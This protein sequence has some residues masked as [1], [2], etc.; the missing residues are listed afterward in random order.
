VK[1]TTC[2]L[3]PGCQP[4][5]FQNDSLWQIQ[6]TTHSISP[7]I[8]F[9]IPAHSFNQFGSILLTNSTTHSIQF[10]WRIPI[11]STIRNQRIDISIFRKATYTLVTIDLYR[12]SRIES[13]V[14]STVIRIWDIIIPYGGLREPVR[15]Q[16]TGQTTSNDRSY[17]PI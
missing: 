17:G 12:I 3:A 2:H 8:S 13:S 7:T 11:Q 5:V 16:T 14:I 10:F 4:T 15:G 9:P 1:Q 6:H